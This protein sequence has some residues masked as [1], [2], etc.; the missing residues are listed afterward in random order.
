MPAL[1]RPVE[2]NPMPTNAP[3]II[4]VILGP[5]FL[6]IKLPKNAPKQKKHIV[7]VKLNA[8]TESLHSNSLLKGIFK[9]DQAYNTPEKS[10][11]FHPKTSA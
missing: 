2:T 7:N 10:R 9:I 4:S 3:A 5:I 11:S 1:K 6:Q 8:K